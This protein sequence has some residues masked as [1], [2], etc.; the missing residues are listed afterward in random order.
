MPRCV[1]VLALLATTP[2]LAQ[3]AEQEARFAEAIAAVEART[4]AFYV[5]VDPRFGA[6]LAPAEEDPAFRE[7]R[8]CVLSRIEEDGGPEMLEEYIAAMEAQGETEITSL[9]DLAAGLPEVLTADI[10]FAASAECGPMSHSTRQMATPEFMQL[11]E[12]PAVMRR[13]MGG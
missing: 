9:I 7:S 2:A 5:S 12:E 13:L 1:L 3:T 6:L 11:M 10:V 4:R 8:R